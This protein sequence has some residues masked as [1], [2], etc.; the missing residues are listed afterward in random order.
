MKYK[1]IQRSIL[2][3]Q[4][5]TN[6]SSKMRK[7]KTMEQNQYKKLLRTKDM[8]PDINA[9]LSIYMNE[10]RHTYHLAVP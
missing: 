2:E 8:F 9:P 5:L 4:Q 3:V 1:K 10:K 6:K 7:Q